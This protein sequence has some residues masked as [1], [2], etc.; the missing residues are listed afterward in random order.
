[1]TPSLECGPSCRFPI[2]DIDAALVLLDK[3]NLRLG[4]AQKAVE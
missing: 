4:Y 3:L 1:M 2:R